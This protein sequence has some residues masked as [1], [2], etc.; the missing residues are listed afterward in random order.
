METCQGDLLFDPWT[1]SSASLWSKD[2]TL[3]MNEEADD[4]VELIDK[5]FAT[6]RNTSEAAKD[7]QSQAPTPTTWETMPPMPV[8]MVIPAEPLLNKR[9]ATYLSDDECVVSSDIPE[10][11]QSRAMPSSDGVPSAS[12][13]SLQRNLQGLYKCCED[14]EMQA[15]KTLHHETHSRIANGSRCSHGQESEQA[16]SIVLAV[17]VDANSDMNAKE[18]EPDEVY[19]KYLDT[20][21]SDPFST[22]E[23]QPCTF[24]PER[25]LFFRRHDLVRHIKTSHICE[26]PFPCDVCFLKFKRKSHRDMHVKSV[27]EKCLSFTCIYCN[28]IYSSDST[29]RKHC[30]IAHHTT[31]YD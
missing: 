12:I 4:I 15:S 31:I 22:S 21:L 5:V 20:I 2:T 14:H 8:F 7:T 30:R 16:K 28:R 6:R 10:R 29:R 24:C 18:S 9:K 11:K 3:N 27:H 23:G 26:R 25:G 1:L 13:D 19:A 17:D